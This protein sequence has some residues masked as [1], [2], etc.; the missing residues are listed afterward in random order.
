MKKSFPLFLLLSTLCVNSGFSQSFTEWHDP[1]VNQIN[2][3]PMRSSFFAYE[4]N[5]LANN[6][7]QSKSSRFMSL[8]GKWKF[9]WVKDA[10]KRPTDFFKEDYNILGWDDISVPGIWEMQGYGDAIYTNSAYEW[11]TLGD[12][13]PPMLPVLDN[14]VGS[15]ARDFI[16]PENWNG[17]DIFYHVG[18]IT[19]NMYL[20]INGKFVGYSEDSKLAAEFNITKYVKPGKNRIAMQTFRWCDGTFTED[21]DFFRLRGIARNVYMYARPKVRLA[22]VFVKTILD[23][24][25][26]DAD[27]QIEPSFTGK[28]SK[29]TYELTLDGKSVASTSALTGNVSIKVSDPLKWSAESPTLYNL[30]ISVYN[31]DNLS[32][33]VDQKVGFRSVEL[34]NGNI[35]VNGKPVLI[36]GVDRH[37]IDPDGGYLVSK[38]RMIQDIELLKKFNFNAVRT[39]HYPDAPIWYDLCDQYGIYLVDEANIEAHGHEAIADDIRFMPAH[40]ERSSRMQLRDKN[41]PSVIFWS[42]GNESGSGINFRTIYNEMKAFD[43]TRVVQYQRTMGEFEGKRYS[44][45]YCDFYIHFNWLEDVLNSPEKKKNILA[46]RPIIQCEYAHAMGNSM[47][48][49]DYYWE[50]TRKYPE[51]QGGFIW[52]FVDQGIRDYRNGKMIYAYGGDY[53]K[54]FAESNN[55]CSNGTVN[56]DRIPNP[57]MYEVGYVQQ[58]IW[59]KLKDT[60]NLV[61]SVY[62]ENFFTDLSNYRLCWSLLQNGKA[63]ESGVVDNIDVKPQQTSEVKLGKVNTYPGEVLLNISYE[64]KKAYGILPAGH[65]AARQQIVIQN[66]SDYTASVSNS[67]EKL[68]IRPNKEAL[69]IE[70]QNFYVYFNKKSGMIS[71]YVVDGR[72]MLKEGTTIRPSFWRAPTDNDFGSGLQVRMRKWLNPALNLKDFKYEEKDNNIVVNTLYELPDVSATLII[73]YV[74]NGKGEISVSEDMK[75]KENNDAPDMFRFGME[76]TMPKIFDRVEYY[77]RGPE[78]N[79]C[80]RNSGSFIGHYTSLVADQYFPYIRPQESGNKTDVRWWK[81]CSVSNRGLEFTSDKPFSASAL[82]FLMSDLDEG[83]DKEPHTHSGELVPQDLTNVHIDAAQAGLSCEDCWGALPREQYRLHAKGE[84]KFNFLIKPVFNLGY[85]Y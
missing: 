45:V 47:G 36:K 49:F 74:V 54:Y 29:V 85:K 69:M 8:E 52:D 53:G 17:M 11:T 66:Y 20:W 50:L 19:S 65:T 51:F 2:R 24:D 9:M 55:F 73:D 14:N 68:S 15:Y 25:Y 18:S 44:D 80:D 82:N 60:A 5:D 26:R 30:R 16:I 59:T 23:S 1:A 79:Y 34:K 62:N 61:L 37:E 6:A 64:L 42:M 13:E 48:S 32:E 67:E 40:K 12:F 41:H 58:N 38:E 43:P 35:L 4:S 75:F 28:P 71:D 63:V 76:V 81:V 33:V 77:G 57:H 27:L 3:E 31:G 84:Y 70:G 10:D 21:Q 78:E 39:C 7:D 46:G 83:T 22:D 72:S 56:P